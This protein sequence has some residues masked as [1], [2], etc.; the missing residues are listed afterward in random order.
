MAV[1]NILKYNDPVLKE[2]AFQV[3]KV[4]S[5]VEKLLDNLIDTMNDAPGIGL[6]APQIGVPKR[7]I[8]VKSEENEEIIEL[9]NP[10]IVDFS[11][12]QE[13][14][15][16]ACLSVPGIQGEVE[17]HVDITVEGLNRKGEKVSIKANGFLARA[18]QHEIDHL[19][20]ILFIDRADRLMEN[21][22]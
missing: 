13:K 7:V 15:V 11:K 12:E 17:R 21:K 8:V 14:A 2:K 6:A 10:V 5:N 9:I 22:E 20:G 1:Y 19:D 16:E 4:N 18:L 3:K